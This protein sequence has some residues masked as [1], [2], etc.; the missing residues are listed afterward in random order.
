MSF[1]TAPE[2]AAEEVP[3]TVEAVEEEP[4]TDAE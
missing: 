3:E 2:A 1:G 4:K